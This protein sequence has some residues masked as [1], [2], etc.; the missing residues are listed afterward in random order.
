MKTT[1]GSWLV[2]C[3]VLA[4]APPA[5]GFA[6]SLSAALGATKLDGLSNFA[7]CQNQSLGYRDKL[8]ADRIEAK[9]RVSPALNEKEREVWLADVRALRAVTPS[10]SKFVPPNPQDPQQYM[11]G[12]T[13]AEQQAINSMSIRF[14]Q[15][16]NLECEKKYGGMTR[17]SPGSDQSGQKRYEEQLRAN[18]VTP[19]DIATV[20]VG[21]LDSPF[22]KTQEQVAAERRTAREAQ[23]AQ[24]QAA[25]GAAMQGVMAKSA[26][27]QAEL[28][29]LRLTIMADQMQR[30]LAA[31]QGLSAKERAD[32]EA[33]IRSVRDGAAQ[34]LDMP[35]PVD[36]AN[37]MR[38][39]MRLT[40]Q[41]QV[42]V[43]TEFGAKYVQQMTA[44]QAR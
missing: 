39:M 12:L 38:A 10:S 4:L 5:A 11:L 14:G 31:S 32:F 1:K 41:D 16:V 25:V 13:D 43:G 34:G 28:K 24:Q 7:D 6:Q 22:P 30:T 19:I 29:G 8:I 21:A 44:C 35:P 40:T 26:A 9:L 36:P 42:A 37:P 20:P 27:C 18:M 3:T 33:D 23:R 2:L 15:E 17:Y